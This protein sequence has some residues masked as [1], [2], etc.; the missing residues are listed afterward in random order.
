[1][2]GEGRGQRHCC[3]QR[4]H[5]GGSVVPVRPPHRHPAPLP[6]ALTSSST[7]S[8]LVSVSSS[9]SVA[10][11]WHDGARAAAGGRQGGGGGW[12]VWRQ[13]GGRRRRRRRRRAPPPASLL[14]A[15]HL[16]CPALAG[17][18]AAAAPL[19]CWGVGGW[20][21]SW[22]R[23]V[24]RLP[25]APRRRCSCRR[26]EP[27]SWRGLR[28]FRGGWGLGLGEGQLSLRALATLDEVRVCDGRLRNSGLGG[29]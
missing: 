24:G 28:L 6:P 16:C 14:H 3:S 5:S 23:P 2:A 19:C 18:A 21:P 17:A 15:A 20:L 1:M 13:A 22:A 12:R 9:V 29:L 26:P 10:A 27:G 25:S 7:V 4:Q 8:T 11:A